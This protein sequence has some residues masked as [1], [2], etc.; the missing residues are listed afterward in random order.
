MASLNVSM[1]D[2]L[3]AFI[4]ERAERGGFSTPSEYVRHLVR[5]DRKRETLEE[6]LLQAVDEGGLKDLESDFFD[7]LRA[8]LPRMKKRKKQAKRAGR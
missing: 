4:M 2:E 3:R 8:R 5:E 1:P 7:R 6:K